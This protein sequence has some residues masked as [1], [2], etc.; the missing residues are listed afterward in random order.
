[1]ATFA[2]GDVQGCFRTLERLLSRLPFERGRDRLWLA[3]DLVN[4]GPRSLAVLRWARGL[5]DSLVTVLGNHDLHLVGRALGVRRKKPGDTLDEVLDAPDRDELVAWLRARPLLHREGERLLVHAGLQPAWTPDAAA[6]LARD[7]EAVLQGPG[8]AALLA[9]LSRRDLP[10]WRP[11]LSARDRRAVA[12]QTFS[13]MR[14]CRSDGRLCRD[15]SGPPGGAPAGCAPW[16]EAPRRS[17]DVTVVCGHWAALG[18]RR[19]PGLLALD[20]GCVWGGA[21]T[22]VRLEDG[23]VFQEPLADR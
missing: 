5:G 20:S 7:L 4:R 21:L 6:E 10:G 15:Y 1:V 13:L 9:E 22:A 17:R 11:R 3:G 14:T 16:F 12:L 19:E 18:F 23:T 8:A 2:I